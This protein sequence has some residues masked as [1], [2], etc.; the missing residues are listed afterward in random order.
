RR[1]R[2]KRQ[3]LPLERRAVSRIQRD[4]RWNAF[5]SR[6]AAEQLLIVLQIALQFADVSG[7]A[8]LNH[9]PF[10]LVRD[11]GGSR[12]GEVADP[13]VKSVAFA[14][15]QSFDGERAVVPRGA[16]AA[17]EVLPGARLN[18][19]DCID[20]RPLVGQ[21]AKLL[22]IE[23][24]AHD[25]TAAGHRLAISIDESALQRS[26][27]LQFDVERLLRIAA[28]GDQRADLPLLVKENKCPLRL[29]LQAVG[30]EL[31]GRELLRSRVIT[32]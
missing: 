8:G 18:V 28:N 20:V 29:R 25:D 17:G 5:R 32:Y 4:F 26:E 7:F 6:V 23:D 2:T 1:K 3:S 11:L 22:G 15:N 31:F 21:V 16:F 10:V 14:G 27:R 12:P 9:Q 24:K 13:S 30:R 19:E